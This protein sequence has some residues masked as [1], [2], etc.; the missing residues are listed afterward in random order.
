M[1]PKTNKEELWSN[2]FLKAGHVLNYLELS[3]LGDLAD[4]TENTGQFTDIEQV[5]ELCGSRQQ[6]LSYGFPES[7][8][9]IDKVTSH[10]DDV[11]RIL[12]WVEDNLKDTTVDVLNRLVAGGRDVQREELAFETVGDIIATSSGVVHGTEELKVADVLELATFILR[13]EVETLLVYQLTCNFK[14]NLISPGVDEGHAHI[15]D[16]DCEIFVSDGN[17]YTGLFAFDL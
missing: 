17:E 16:E 2:L 1:A 3:L 11:L 13:Q 8:G 10:S 7:D 4:T 9:G 15:I 14:G 12:L 5:V 6:F